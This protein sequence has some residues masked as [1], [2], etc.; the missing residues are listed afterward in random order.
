MGR[1]SLSYESLTTVLCDAEAV[2]NSRP[3]TYVS[4]DPLDLK[5]L[6]PSMF[7]QDIKETGVP[8]CDVLYHDKL[9]KKLKYKQMLKKNLRERF[10][11]EYLSQLVL[12]NGKKET[13]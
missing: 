7:L 1:A 13:R 11:I 4:E 8:D 3:V 2:I 5:A 6:S 12:K 10:R 9:N